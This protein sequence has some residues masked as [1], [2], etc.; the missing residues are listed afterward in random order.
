MSKRQRHKYENLNWLSEPRSAEVI[1]LWR[2]LVTAC[3]YA[4]SLLV[5]W[6][7]LLFVFG[8]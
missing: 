4:A 7:V 5:I 1:P 2:D 8:P 3:G 6:I